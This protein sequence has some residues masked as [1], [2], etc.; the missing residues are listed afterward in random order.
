MMKAVFSRRSPASVPSGDARWG[1]C[2]YPRKGG[3]A[4]WWIC[5]KWLGAWC[6]GLWSRTRTTEAYPIFFSTST[7][8]K[9]P[10]Y[11]SSN[12]EAIV[13]VDARHEM[14]QARPMI[15]NVTFAVR[16]A[17]GRR[18]APTDALESKCDHLKRRRAIA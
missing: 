17:R 6:V 15:V 1:L 4:C 16:R 12:A 10:R 18:I 9:A 5:K 13:S 14:A 3:R 2:E 11:G 7:Q 8:E